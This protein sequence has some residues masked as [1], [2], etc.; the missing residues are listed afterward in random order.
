[1]EI[2]KTIKGTYGEVRVTVQIH[3]APTSD[4]VTREGVANLVE[5]AADRFNDQLDV[6]YQ[7]EPHESAKT[8]YVEPN[9]FEYND[10]VV[11]I[12]CEASLRGA[13]S[14]T[15]V[16]SYIGLLS[17]SLTQLLAEYL[18]GFEGSLESELE[19]LMPELV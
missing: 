3:G 8:R 4:M 18:G 1:M 14:L 16:R 9:G 11:K 6:L 7:P 2:V 5:S 12:Q 19:A 13:I 15:R 17:E 10:M